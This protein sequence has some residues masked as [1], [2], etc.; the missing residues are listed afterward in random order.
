MSVHRPVRPE[1]GF[2]S[3]FT[4]LGKKLL[5]L[6]AVIYALEL[7]LFHWFRTPL[8]TRLFLH[9]LGHPAFGIW[10]VITHPFVHDPNAPLGF[11]IDC[12]VFYFFAAPVERSIG[13]RRFL[14]LF[15]GAAGAAAVCGIAF[16]LL[17][18][19]AA[20]FGGML[21][22]LL[23]L[24]VVFGLLNPDATILLMFILPIKAKYI[25]Y[26]TMAVTLLTFL[27]KANPNGAFHLGGV[28]FGYLWLNGPRHALDPARLHMRYLE[29]RLRRK[30]SRFRVI[31]GDKD[32][33]GPTYH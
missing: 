31:D 2:G 1:F 20:P 7:I 22:S 16:G 9:P 14:T 10:Q 29:W 18:E 33:D 4:E 27:A 24:V 11:L 5:I 28:L 8:V 15:Y 17:A 19:F 30:K 25:A 23:A 21:P 26:G 32:K 12:L 3:G 13:S 6:Y